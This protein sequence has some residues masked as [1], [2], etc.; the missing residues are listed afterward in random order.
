MLND[1]DRAR[2]SAAITQ[3][4]SKTSGEIFCV[5]ARR[6]SRYREIPLL[7][8]TV[9]GFLVPP[10]LVQLLPQHVLQHRSL[11][12]LPAVDASEAPLHLQGRQSFSAAMARNSPPAGK[13]TY[14]R[15]PSTRS[16]PRGHP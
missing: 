16:P 9:A 7:W 1:K 13:P 15:V 2:I 14:A 3:A 6:V 8:A 4:E 11:P 10:A 5:L 12:L